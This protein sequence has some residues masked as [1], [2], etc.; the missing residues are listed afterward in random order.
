MWGKLPLRLVIVA[1]LLIPSLAYLW[2]HSDVPKFC[3]LHDDCLYFVSA[4][5][6]V[7]GGGYRIASLPGEP[8][9]T[10]YPPLYPLLLSVAW[11]I[12]PQFPS[13]LTPAIWISW[14]A[15]PALLLALASFYPRIGL[16]GWRTWVLLGLIAINPYTITFSATLLS[17]LF[18][19]SLLIG[20]LILAERA[21]EANG[22]VQ[23]AAFAGIVMGLAYLARSAGIVALGTTP[24]FFLLRKQPRKAV[25]FVCGMLPFVAGWML[26]AKLHQ[27]HTTD[28]ALMY[29]VDY[30]GYQVYN[31]SFSEL[32][33]LLWKNVDGFLAGIGALVLPSVFE[34]LFMK[35][36]SQVIAVAMISG[37]VRMV[38]R[39]QAVNYALF[40]LGSAFLLVI[41]HFPPNERFV[42]PLYPLAIAGLLVELEHLAQMLKSGFRHVDRSQRIA[43]GMFGSGVALFLAAALGLQVYMTTVFL[44]EDA[45]QFREKRDAQVKAY[46]WIKQNTPESAVVLTMR[47]P[48][49][50]LQTGHHAISRPVPPKLWYRDDRQGVI[51]HF[52]SMI[53]FART[54]EL[55]YVYYAGV[56][57]GW[58]V[59]EQDK[60][61][62]NESIRNN[63]EMNVAFRDGDATVYRVRRDVLA[64][65]TA[66]SAMAAPNNSVDQPA[67]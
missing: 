9:Q 63:P 37:I 64:K 10:K 61:K 28:P 47:D 31:V 8:S 3:D 58:S 22:R 44:P 43:A 52:G 29:Y 46:E 41:W 38:R 16:S 12:N 25:A 30:A 33:I 2:S 6:L 13:N 20:A 34:G 19:A 57:F 62:I 54:H 53:L 59:D 26:W 1:L 5:S 40:A 27:L 36:L 51:D 17:E 48:L 18:F 39:G 60:T 11:R 67:H 42:Y 4:K 65:S 50:Y 24:L 32:H 56:D 7:D 23:T 35:I 45:R 14:L 55:A 49:F 66:N 21:S 15:L